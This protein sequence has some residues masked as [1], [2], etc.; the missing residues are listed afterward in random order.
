VCGIVGSVGREGAVDHI[1]RGLR[2][3]EYRGYDSA[4]LAVLSLGVVEVRRTV[5]KLVNLEQSVRKEDLPGGIGVGHTRWATHGKP[6]RANAHP[7]PGRKGELFLVHNGIVENYRELKEALTRRGHEFQSET[8]SEVLAHLIEEEVTDDLL[9]GLCRALRQVRGAFAVL[10][11]HRRFPD[12]LVGARKDSPLVVGVANDA[13]YVA[14]DIP[15]LLEFTRDVVFLDDGEA[16][17]LRCDGITVCD[18]DGNLHEKTAER[19]EWD[20]LMAE[21]GGYKH[22]M[23][24]EIHEQPGAV[25]DA[26][27]GRL[28]QSP[29]DDL[30]TEIVLDQLTEIDRVVILACGTS[31]HAGL[32][33]KAWIEK[34]AKIPVEVAIASE[35]RHQEPLVGPRS[36]V[37]AISQSGETL[38]TLAAARLAKGRGAPLLSICNV[39]GSSLA[40]D[41]GSVLYTRAGP[42]IG[43]ASTKAFTTQLLA[44]RLLA[45]R[46]GLLRKTLSPD[47]GRDLLEALRPLRSQMEAVLRLEETIK[48]VASRYYRAP[49]VLFLGRGVN[50][51]IALEGA[52]KL[53]EISYIHAEGYP[54]GEMKHGPI[55][56]I[57][58]DVPIVVVAP[59]GGP[60]EKVLGNMEEARARGGRV[61]AVCTEGD[62]RVPELAHDILAV[63]SC[64]P[65]L[66]P[67]LTVLPLQLL[68]YYT[69]LRRGCDIDQPRNLA[70]SV[71]VE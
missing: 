1:L 10:V 55:A 50:Y 67:F 40:R 42:E 33:G 46:L 14:S 51:P 57:D 43:V 7:H 68:A 20:L 29:E 35:F 24:K 66:S 69:A 47:Q 6:T 63:P 31:Y 56:L 41:S 53:K 61:I 19:I 22:F 5:G 12:R 44:L 17:E 49:D 60:Y 3:L 65:D 58:E 64:E 23:L 38:D 37:V 59:Q 45:I 21:K 8:D 39:M 2:R 71:T 27:L 15:A 32:I 34:L 36:P 30:L 52:L 28:P 26:L 48:E 25:S 54:A 4:G 13:T 11:L 70:K 16:I 9:G 62:D 18:F